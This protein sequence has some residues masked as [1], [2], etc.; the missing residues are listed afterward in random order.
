VLLE[1]R[2]DFTGA[3]TLY[4]ELTQGGGFSSVMQEAMMRRS[5]LLKEHPDLAVAPTPSFLPPGMTAPN[6]TNPLLPPADAPGEGEPGPGPDPI[7]IPV[8]NA[9]SQLPEPDSTEP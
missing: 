4:T 3:M 8:P 1:E 2:E 5:E 7:E 6:G 9:G